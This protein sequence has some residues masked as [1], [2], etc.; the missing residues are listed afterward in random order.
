M[1]TT[2]D[3]FGAI[4]I[5]MLIGKPFE[6]ACE[7]QIMLADATANYIKEVGFLPPAQGDTDGLGPLRTA[8][9]GFQRPNAADATKH[10]EVTFEVPFIVC[11][12]TPALAIKTVDVTFDMEV[13]TASAS[14]ES[15]DASAGGTLTV[16]QRWPGGAGK[17]SISGSV[18]SHKENTRST[19]TSAK[20]HISVHAEDTGMPEGLQRVMNILNN[21]ITAPPPPAQVT[22]SPPPPPNTSPPPP[23]EDPNHL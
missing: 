4:P 18:S 13:R 1:T 12:N 22:Q 16:Q 6:A 21:A 20:Y 14:V 2:G 7:A 10:D 3:E 11:V 23:P 8:K 5:A 15:E 17:L 19:D 9:F